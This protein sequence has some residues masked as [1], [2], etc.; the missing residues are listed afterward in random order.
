MTLSPLLRAGRSAVPISRTVND[1]TKT[2]VSKFI[3]T[4]NN[5]YTNLK[6]LYKKIQFG[7]DTKLKK[8]GVDKLCITKL[9]G[10]KASVRFYQRTDEGTRGLTLEQG[11]PEIKMFFNFLKECSSKGVKPDFSTIKALFKVLKINPFN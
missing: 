8:M 6:G 9:P 10:E 2:V 1:K 5:P 4:P 11:T 3:F 7:Q